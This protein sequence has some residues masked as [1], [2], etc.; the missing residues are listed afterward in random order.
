MKNVLPL[1]RSTYRLLI[2]LLFA[3]IFLPNLLTAQPQ[4][5]FYRAWT[6][7]G[8]GVAPGFINRVVTIAGSGTAYYTA[9]SVLIST[10]NYGMRLTKFSSSG[11]TSWVANFDLGMGGTTHVGGVA[12]DASGNIFVTGTAYNGTTN[13]HDLYLVKYNSSGVKQWQR[14]YTGV[15]TGT[16]VGSAVVCNSSGD[17]FVTG[18][19]SQTF[20]NMDALT[21][22]Y[23]ASGTLV[24]DETWDNASLIDAGAT[25]SLL[26]TRVIVTG[27]SQA[28]FTT[29]EYAILRYEQSNGSL[30][31]A[32]VTNQGGTNIELVSAATTDAA[33]NVYLTGAL[34]ATGQGFNIK[35]IKLSPSLAILWTANWNGTANLDDAGRSIAVD[36]SG[37]VFVA[38]YT[39]ASDHDGILL[40]YS[41]SGSLLYATG[42]N[43][44][45]D[46]EFTGIALT[47]AQDVFVGGYNSQSGNK[48]FLAQFYTNAGTLR[49]SDSYNGYA[50][51]DDAAQQVTPDGYGNFLLSGTSGQS[52]L[53]VKYN[54]HS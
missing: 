20:P 24:W 7:T 37:N 9:N 51:E 30:V 17:V 4:T 36:T 38:G 54:R 21:L 22:C 3:G 13:G 26:G 42:D 14:T 16:D 34:G 39:T 45:G 35:T 47:S 23:S 40:K 18:M 28:N 31:S 27:A 25:L 29:W 44:A 12:L 1:Q 2:T 32:I 43:A 50:N 46:D 19:A 6:Q 11:N 52:T 15:G 8:G 5:F 33:G 10:N 48:D 41:P 49:W 53:T